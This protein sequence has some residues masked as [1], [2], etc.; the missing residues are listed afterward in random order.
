MSIKMASFEISLH[1]PIAISEIA[2]EF[3]WKITFLTIRDRK[4][5][6]IY[7]KGQGM[8]EALNAGTHTPTPTYLYVHLHIHMN[9][10]ICPHITNKQDTIR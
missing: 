4:E 3:T 6:L 5:K 9:V 2:R 1:F 10:H 7:Q 8:G